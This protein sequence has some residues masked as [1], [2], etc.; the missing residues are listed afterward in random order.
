MTHYEAVSCAAIV[1]CILLGAAFLLAV[2]VPVV[3]ALLLSPGLM[4]LSL[5]LAHILEGKP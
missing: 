2:G 4:L 5:V 1:A 3:L